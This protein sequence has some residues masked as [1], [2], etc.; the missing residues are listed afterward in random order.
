MNTLIRTL[1]FVAFTLVEYVRSGRILV[2]ILA[3]V[4]FFYLFF[5]RSTSPMS[6]D[7]FF[8]NTGLFVLGLTFY[9][10]SATMGLGDRPQGYI[11]MVRRLGRVGYLIGLYIAALAITWGA[12]GVISIGVALYNPVAELDVADWL[13]GTTPLLLNGALFGA[14]LTLLAPMVLTAGWRLAV[15]GVVAIAFSGNLLSGQTLATM[16][17]PLATGL[18][19]LRTIFSAPLLP[20]FA[21]FQLSIDRDYHGISILTPI[22]QISLT[23]GLLTLAVYAFTQRDLIFS[24]S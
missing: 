11:L 20:A 12:Y 23:L 18:N 14:L 6:P 1:R 16:P 9:T 13:L 8:A 21:G 3:T 7:Y 19:V 17:T 10:T 2:E 4:A 5:R 15:L 22:A 24:S